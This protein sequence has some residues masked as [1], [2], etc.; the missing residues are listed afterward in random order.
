MN[1]RTYYTSKK[2]MFVV[3]KDDG[4]LYGK[5]DTDVFCKNEKMANKICNLLNIGGCLE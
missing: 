1:Y 3:T 2:D 5:Y 4:T